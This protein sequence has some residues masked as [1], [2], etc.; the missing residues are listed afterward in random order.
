MTTIKLAS[1]SPSLTFTDVN[2]GVRFVVHAFLTASD[3]VYWWNVRSGQL[4]NNYFYGKD[5]VDALTAIRNGASSAV[6]PIIVPQTNPADDYPRGDSVTIYGRR[7]STYSGKN[8]VVNLSQNGDVVTM[9]TPITATAS[10]G[11]EIQDA[12]AIDC[13]QDAARGENNA[14]CRFNS[15]V[16][17]VG[18]FFKE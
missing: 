8:Q 1:G 7:L 10:F 16:F 13:L 15:N 18:T 9:T 3:F 17:S 11:L 6:V 12:N 2:G 5:L 14:L 4:V